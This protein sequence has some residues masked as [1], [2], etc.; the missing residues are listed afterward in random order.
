MSVSYYLN[1]M[2][3]INSKWIKENGEDW[4]GGRIDIRGI[5]DED[6]YLGRDEYGVGIMKCE[7]WN[8]LYDFLLD[9]KSEDV[10]PY[11]QLIAEFEENHGKI[12]WFKQ[13]GL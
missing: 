5:D 11:K 7:D 3:P 6:Y 10:I 12:R 13:K 4:C 1:W 9:K 2:G 8:A